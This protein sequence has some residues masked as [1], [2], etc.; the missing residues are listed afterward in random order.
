MKTS[1]WSKRIT[2]SLF[3]LTFGYLSAFAGMDSYK[4]FL[5]KKLL[6]EKIVTEPLNA[7]N[8]SNQTNSNDEIV[9]YYSHCGRQ[10]SERKIS[11]KDSKGAVVKEWSFSTAQ[12]GMAIPVKEIAALQK[13]YGEL[14][15]QDES[16]ELPQGRTLA[17]LNGNAKTVAGIRKNEALDLINRM[18]I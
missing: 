7:I 13:Q 2:L 5:N 17:S 6:F 16:H 3:L 10:G 9:I 18:T 8:L 12:A 15:L 1:V 4:V 11:L 14:T